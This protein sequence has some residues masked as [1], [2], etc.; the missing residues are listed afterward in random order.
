[1][2]KYL[3]TYSYSVSSTDLGGAGALGLYT[4]VDFAIAR[5]VWDFADEADMY[6]DP[7]DPDSWY[8]VDVYTYDGDETDADVA[9]EKLMDEID[10]DN[11]DVLHINTSLNTIKVELYGASFEV[12]GPI[13]RVD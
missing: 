4:G 5:A 3:A 7:H 13:R 11:G 2:T 6:L 8:G 9:Y 10:G 12:H 1:M